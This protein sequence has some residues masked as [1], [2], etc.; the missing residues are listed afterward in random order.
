MTTGREVRDGVEGQ[1]K[2]KKKKALPIS[3]CA[4]W[5]VSWWRAEANADVLG[6]ER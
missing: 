6:L 5:R 3:L 2:K 4:T 1:K